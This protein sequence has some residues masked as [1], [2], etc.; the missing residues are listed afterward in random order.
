[1]EQTYKIIVIVAIL[2]SVAGGGAFIGY[3]FAM[4]NTGDTPNGDQ[5]DDGTDDMDVPDESSELS[6]P[7][8]E[9]YLNTVNEPFIVS[10][11]LTTT[12]DNA[13]DRIYS[14]RYYIDP[15][16][17]YY[18]HHKTRIGSNV[19]REYEEYYLPDSGYR[20]EDPDANPTETNTNLSEISYRERINLEGYL[21]LDQ[22]R[23]TQEDS[24]TYVLETSLTNDPVRE[25]QGYLEVTVN[26]NNEKIESVEVYM[27]PTEESQY[28]GNESTLTF[29]FNSYEEPEF[30]WK[31]DVN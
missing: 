3:S 23:W 10:K 16:V 25:E 19:Q 9:E 27:L 14:D 18:S 11:K 15:E 5:P 2:L 4:D 22:D 31:E 20:K 21:T 17:S 1:M 12:F 7:V 30:Y 24:S 13:E 29:E 28:Y 6:S 8:R 26:L